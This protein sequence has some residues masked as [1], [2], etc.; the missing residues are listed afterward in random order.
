MIF[1]ISK[2]L[3]TKGDRIE[4]IIEGDVD[5]DVLADLNKIDIGQVSTAE[6]YKNCYN[7]N[8]LYYLININ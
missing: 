4:T 1:K 8:F 7:E 6:E 2:K 3:F 5:L